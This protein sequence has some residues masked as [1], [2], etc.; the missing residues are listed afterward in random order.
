MSRRNDEPTSE[1]RRA[2]FERAGD[3]SGLR[4]SLMGW[5]FLIV[6]VCML[7]IMSPVRVVRQLRR[8][9]ASRHVLPMTQRTNAPID[10]GMNPEVSVRQEAMDATRI[11][12]AEPDLDISASEVVAASATAFTDSADS[13]SL[14]SSVSEMDA[15]V[16]DPVQARESGTCADQGQRAP[17]VAPTGHRGHRSDVLWAIV[18]VQILMVAELMVLS[19]GFAGVGVHLLIVV[20]VLG[21]WRRAESDDRA[22]L[23]MA[24][25]LPPLTR[26]IAVL[27]SLIGQPLPEQSVI[28]VLLLLAAV[29]GIR[30]SGVRAG[31]IG[32]GR[33]GLVRQLPILVLGLG[34][35][36]VE[37]LLL[38]SPSAAAGRT[39]EVMMLASVSVG[40]VGVMQELLF[41][42][43]LQHAAIRVLG[44]RTGIV[45][46]AATLSVL[47]IPMLS[48]ADMAV[49]FGSGLILS[50]QVRR[51]GSILGVALAHGIASAV[52]FV[53]M[54]SGLLRLMVDGWPHGLVG[55]WF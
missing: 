22:R 51:T 38:D 18:Y 13:T 36:F 42:G 26:I 16:D 53:W 32:C 10:V 4:A 7:V 33:V 6:W 55:P 41:R 20:V 9:S 29:A 54:P 19:V 48:L 46:T 34:I 44:V 17:D 50:S 3:H 27:A 45:V 2:A 37:F 25:V 39:P 30:A 12:G 8:R 15:S 21:L 28:A 23:L 11:L 49:V 43:I 52:L 47:A 31:Q 14:A 1:S 40:L 5:L 24:L 35:G